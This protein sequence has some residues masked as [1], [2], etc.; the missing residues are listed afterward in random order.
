[1]EERPVHDVK[2]CGDLTEE[3]LALHDVEDE[4]PSLDGYSEVW[5]YK[6]QHKQSPSPH[7][8]AKKWHDAF[9]SLEKL[10]ASKF[11]LRA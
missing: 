4:N 11:R 6:T 10:L 1:M 2:I 8:F 5:R 3:T 7:T 9:H